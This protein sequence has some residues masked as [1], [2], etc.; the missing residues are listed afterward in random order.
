MKKKKAKRNVKFRFKLLL[1]SAFL[2][3]AGLSIYTQQTNINT[4]KSE[5]EALMAE[6]E[7]A[8]TELSRLEYKAEYMNTDNYVED[9]AREKFGLVY[10]GEIILETGE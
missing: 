9:T 4:L 1:L 3:Y 2:V 10:E 7:Q 5:Q 8:Q 6:Y